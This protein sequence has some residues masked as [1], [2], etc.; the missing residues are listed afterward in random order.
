MPKEILQLMQVQAEMKIGMIKAGISEHLAHILAAEF[1]HYIA[2]SPV[3]TKE[4]KEAYLALSN[5]SSN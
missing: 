5:D 3:V 4:H 1:L 2:L